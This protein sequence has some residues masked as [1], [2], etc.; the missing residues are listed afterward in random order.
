MTLNKLAGL[1]DPAVI[2]KNKREL[3]QKIQDATNQRHQKQL[4]RLIRYAMTLDQRDLAELFAQRSLML[5]MANQVNSMRQEL[6]QRLA[7]SNRINGNRA[8]SFR[9][10]SRDLSKLL[11]KNSNDRKKGALKR[12][13]NDKKQHAKLEARKLWD[14]WKHGQHPRIRTVEQFATETLRRWPVLTSANVIRRWSAQW[15]KETKPAQPC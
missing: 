4:E 14:E 1:F 6:N 8:A 12:H 9:E 2:E 15:T 5:A 3:E 10:I 11:E 13:A 7:D